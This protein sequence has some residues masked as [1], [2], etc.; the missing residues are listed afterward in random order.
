MDV[1]LQVEV[2]EPCI[3]LASARRSARHVVT[4]S[5][6][7]LWHESSRTWASCRSHVQLGVGVLDRVAVPLVV[8]IAAEVEPLAELSEHELHRV[9]SAQLA[10]HRRRRHPVT[11][12]LGRD[13]QAHRVAEHLLNVATAVADGVV[14]CQ[15]HG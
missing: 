15:D 2:V 7:P 9:S 12:V 8:A 4:T 10:Q 11:L 13:Q 6:H 14:V 1:V 5:V 3:Q